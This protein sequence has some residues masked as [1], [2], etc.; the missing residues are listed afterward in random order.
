M[1]RF[2]NDYNRAAHPAFADALKAASAAG[3]RLLALD[4]RVTP[5]SIEARREVRIVL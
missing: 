4:C 5:D 2:N 3:V 1:I